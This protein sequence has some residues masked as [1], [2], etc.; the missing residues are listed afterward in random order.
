MPAIAVP[1]QAATITVEEVDQPST[2]SFAN[3]SREKKPQRKAFTEG[4]V[5][6]QRT[7]RD[8]LQ[9]KAQSGL[10]KPLTQNY[11]QALTEESSDSDV[12]ETD[13]Q[14]QC[15]GLQVDQENI[16]QAI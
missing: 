16:E 4:I 14:W 13:L 12:D 6:I 2:S 11:F 9:K 10:Q 7:F 15:K 8:F 5:L 3:Q 1:K